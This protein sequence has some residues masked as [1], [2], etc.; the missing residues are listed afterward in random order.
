MYG[1]SFLSR[2]VAALWRA[3]RD[4]ITMRRLY[5][6]PA[7]HWAAI[8]VLSWSKYYS[9]DIWHSKVHL[10]H[11]Y[12]LWIVFNRGTNNTWAHTY[13]DTYMLGWPSWGRGSPSQSMASSWRTWMVTITMDR[14]YPSKPF[15]TLPWNGE[16]IL[17][18]HAYL[19]TY[20]DNETV[21]QS[22]PSR[23]MAA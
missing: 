13:I 16:D 9:T 15:K 2:S 6:R 4:T 23:P 20:I 17:Y 19:H 14:L 5:P 18:I 10:L 11:S 1:A 7:L 12:M 8:V 22:S 3:W 21:C